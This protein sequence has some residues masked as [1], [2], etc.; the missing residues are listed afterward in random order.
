MSKKSLLLFLLLLAFW[1]LISAEINLQHI[2]VGSFLS[3]LIVWFW[4][5]L[6]LRLPGRMT[7]R[8]L[9]HLG[10]CL[11]LLAG[12]VIQA[13]IAVAKVLL[14]P[15]VEVNPVFIEM[16]THIESNWLRVLLAICITIT[17]GTV[18]IDVNPDTGWFIVHALTEDM[19]RDL[20]YWRLVDR[21][22]ELEAI[23]QRR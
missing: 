6:G 12:Y 5:D 3:L 15:K 4:H 18:T 23:N 19:G 10:Y 14:T 2:L 17:P 16:N 7:A 21:I 20:L 8:G 1:L 9:V 11:V 22:R 13:N